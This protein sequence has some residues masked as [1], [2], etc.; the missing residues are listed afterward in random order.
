MNRK[1]VS[2][3]ICLLLLTAFFFIM[4]HSLEMQKVITFSIQLWMNQLIPSLFPFFFLSHFFMEYGM[5]ELLASLFQKLMTK[6]FH[7]KKET[8]FVLAMSMV[9]GFPSGAKY[10][11][12]LLDKKMIDEEEASFL[13][14]FT[15]FSNPLFIL[16]FVTSMLQ[17][18]PSI[19]IVIL[20]VHYLSNF[21]IGFL[22]RPKEKPR[23]EAISLRQGLSLMH[24]KRIHN[25]LNFGQIIK[26]AIFQTFETL[27][28][29]LGTMTF[30]LM[31]TEFLKTVL[32][33]S[34][35]SSSILSGLLEM[36]QGIVKVSSLSI[37]VSMKASLTTFFLS[38]GGLSVHMQVYSII[39]DT[40]IKY[41]KFVKARMIHALLASSLVYFLLLIF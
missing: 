16:G 5:I 21:I 37:P 39:S 6:F 11:R 40:K 30:F 27:V 34:H 38:F 17:S 13:L 3:G 4:T 14:T 28:L 1:L 41:S 20:I 26:N 18:E 12:S 2:I 33:L 8:A 31:I 32:P 36:T 35:L 7:L 24:Q 22:L 19:S 9:S 15:H 10:T 29:M 23:E 25:P